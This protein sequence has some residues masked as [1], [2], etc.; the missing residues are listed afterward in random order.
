MIW[1]VSVQKSPGT[2]FGYQVEADNIGEA[3]IKGEV[4]QGTIVRVC[5]SEYD[6]D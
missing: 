2:I 5:L 4:F 6:E 3:V 1:N